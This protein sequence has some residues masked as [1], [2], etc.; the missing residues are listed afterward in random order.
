MYMLTY[1][2]CDDFVFCF[3]VRTLYCSCNV[4]VSVFRLLLARLHIV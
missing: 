2:P 3:T 4:F 1:E